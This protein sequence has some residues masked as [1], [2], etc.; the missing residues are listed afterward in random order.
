[1]I[2][3]KTLNKEFAS[4]EDMFRELKLNEEKILSL[5]KARVLKSAEKGQI[6]LVNAYLKPEFA[7]KSGIQLDDGFVYP[8]I[9]TTKYMD[10][11]DDVH[12]DGLWKKTLKEQ[13]GKIFYLSNHSMK[14]DDVVAWPEDVEAFTTMIDWSLVGK[15]YPGQTEALIYKIP[16]DKIVKPTA[17]DAIKQR[18]KVQGSVSM[19]YVKIK[20]A[21][22]SDDKEYAENKAFWD[23]HIDEIANKEDVEKQGYFFG[24]SEARIYKEGSLVLFGSNDATEIMYPKDEPLESTHEIEPS[25]DTLEA[26][27]YEYLSKNLFKKK[28]T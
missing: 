8:V 24:V 10:S 15:D 9:N 23:S 21:I 27:D 17:L 5:K 13:Q 4:K 7:D 19:I 3:C 20:L 16:E 25:D 18:R 6:S 28:L 11:H 12:F 14:I 2:Q 22:N 26:I 1:M